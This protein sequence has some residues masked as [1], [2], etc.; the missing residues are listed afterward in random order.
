M[1]ID[2]AKVLV[3]V[4]ALNEEATIGSVVRKVC[5]AGFAVAVVSDGSTDKT[6]EVARTAGAR[7]LEL[8]INLGV[9]G[10]LRAGFRFAVNHDFD[11][12][13][14]IDADDQHPVHEINRLI[15]AANSS[16]AHLVIGS[17]FTS[18][19][20]TLEV[21]FIRRAVMRVLA[22]SASRASGAPITD[23]TSGF[24]LIARPL[25]EEFAASFPSYYLGDTYEALVSAG[26]AGYVI[27]EVPAALRP[28]LVGESSANPRQATQLTLKSLALVILRIHFPIAQHRS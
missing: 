16:G 7:V 21:S 8:P 13:V 12:A 22:R 3:V 2:A 27:R 26:R 11:A 14:Q 15:D 18:D 10:A 5:E 23:A 6:A 25:L 4:P 20:S 19:D 24:R 1:K 9:G 28:R 17:R